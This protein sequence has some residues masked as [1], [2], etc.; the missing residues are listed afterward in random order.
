MIESPF[1]TVIIPSRNEE[2]FL[3]PCLDSVLANDYP[4]EKMEVF[5]V[6]GMSSDKSRHI[7]R[8]YQQVHH[9]IR[10][11]DNPGRIYPSALNIGIRESKGAFIFILGAHASYN[12][13]YFHDCIDFALRF[14]S[15]NTG[16]CL[17]TKGLNQNLIGLSI[18]QVLTNRFGVGNSSFRTGSDKIKETDTVFG[19]C[20]KRDVF[21]R[22]GFFNEKLVSSSDIEFN[23]RLKRSGGKIILIPQI[24]VTYYTRNTFKSF[25]RNNLRNGFWAIFPI[26]FSSHLPVS[27]RHL[28]PLVF[29][30]TLL[31]ILILSLF[32]STAWY[33][34][35]TLGS[36]YLLVSIVFSFRSARHLP[37]FLLTMPPL[38]LLLH[39]TYGVGSLAALFVLS[40]AKKNE[41]II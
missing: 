36:L 7:A 22:I 35:L 16:G 41:K 38:F 27:A 17:V 28:V 18:I 4:K 26:A 11:L 13:T 20:Y 12:N 30:A 10:L 32:Y 3:S 33:V 39:L 31:G 34:L 23:K 9:I 21:E 2:K 24:E 40:F 1:I 29:L 25:F 14:Q 37:L 8:Q 19:G 15:D 6:D 5:I